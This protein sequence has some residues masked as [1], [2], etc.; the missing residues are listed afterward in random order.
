MSIRKKDFVN[1]TR[2]VWKMAI[3]SA[4][5]WELAK[6]AGSDHPYLAP[7]SVIL[8]LQ[9]TIDRSI[10]FSI[11]RIAGTIVGVLLI[12]WVVTHL[13]FN[14]WSLGL[15]LLAGTLAA[16]WLKMDETALH[17][18]AITVLLLFAFERKSGDYGFDRIVDTLI[19][20]AVAVAIHTLLLPPN[21]TKEA[22][23]SCQQAARQLSGLLQEMAGWVQL[24]W[25]KSEKYELEER[26]K[27]SLNSLH[28]AKETLQVATN[29][30]KFNPLSKK[31]KSMLNT[32]R[33]QLQVLAKGYEYAST[34]LNTLREWQ[35]E[36]TLT[37]SDKTVIGNDL[38]LLG[39][40]FRKVGLPGFTDTV[41]KSEIDFLFA[42][43]AIHQKPTSAE[44]RSS[45]E[46]ETR[47]LLKS[48][49]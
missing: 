8:C 36:A 40:F 33:Q 43:K 9:T 18:V 6:F 20:A 11:H 4:I 34:I 14:G 2:L 45:F 26:L 17:Q 1:K 21:F 46:L 28:T 22:S 37:P 47:K 23:R 31:Q 42:R 29:S 13:P 48:L 7:L 38:A 25:G 12:A 35:K 32:T 10:R 39:D 15:L 5:S 24:E 30:L 44:F 3:A 19:G 27:N 41:Q 16:K 49:K